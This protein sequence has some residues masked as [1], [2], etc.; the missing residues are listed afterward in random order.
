MPVTK[1]TAFGRTMLLLAIA[2]TAACAAA[3]PA[4]PR[5]VG[6][7]L[8]ETQ[9][10]DLVA[11]LPAPP[12]EG[13]E[14]AAADRQASE[15]ALQLAN[16]ERWDM[17][18]FDAAMRAPGGAAVFSCAAGLPLGA[19]ET[20]LTWSLLRS[21]AIDVALTTAAPKRAY[22]RARPFTWNGEPV[23]TPD[24]L[25]VLLKDGS[26]PS[27]HAATGW[28]WGLILAELAPDRA[29]AILQRGHAYGQSRVV[30]NVHWQ[31]DVD[32]GRV[33]G[34]AIVARLHG[35]AEFREQLDAARDELDKARRKDLGLDRGCI[36]K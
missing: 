20:P 12:G 10:P 23:C 7:F 1:L 9:R 34:T 22:Q 29:D 30:C 11:L 6:A 2:G 18:V 19:A 33:A 16:T 32:Q 31:S 35:D 21:V 13:T 4:G 24:G 25:K 3:P 27:G 26:Y 15:Q 8:S 17:A 14:A 28:A 5:P 36:D